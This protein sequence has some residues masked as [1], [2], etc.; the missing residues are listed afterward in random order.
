M[1]QD[2]LEIF[3]LKSFNPNSLAFK[4]S[5]GQSLTYGELCENIE[6][7]K[8]N[9]LPANVALVLVKN[10]IGSIATIVG[11]LE[12]GVVP[13]LIDA[14]L[15]EKAIF[16]YVSLYSPEYLVVPAGFSFENNSYLK[17]KNNFDCD[18]LS[19]L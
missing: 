4:D 18:I 2:L 7:F 9:I 12:I 11:L 3:A 5:N 14:Q 13:I 19:P 16:N 6:S 15:N 1:E 8:K 10:T 17:L